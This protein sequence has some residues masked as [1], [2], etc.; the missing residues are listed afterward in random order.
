MLDFLRDEFL[1]LNGIVNLSNLVFIAALSV[2][3]VLPLRLLS[4][5]SSLIIIPYYYFQP[6][7][8]WPSIFWNLVSISINSVRVVQL[9]L[10]RRPVVLAEREGALYRLAFT[11]LDKREFL[12]LASLARWVACSAGD[13][14]LKKNHVAEDAIVLISGEVEARLG[15][16]VILRYRPGELIG[17]ANAYSG[18]PI[19][20]DIVARTPLTLVKWDIAR[21]RAYLESRPELRGRLLELEGADLASKLHALAGISGLPPRTAFGAGA[22]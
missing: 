8:L 12:R 22:S 14:V 17:D 1:G 15:D 3:G 10:E 11:S 19:P 16:K 2:R 6:E 7:T 5:A 20:V 13:V 18:T 9:L 4:I 21:L